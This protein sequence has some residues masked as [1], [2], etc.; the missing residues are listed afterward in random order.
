MVDRLC[1]RWSDDLSEVRQCDC[2][3]RE[4]I[5]GYEHRQRMDFQW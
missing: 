3:K 2:D 4:W 5:V 1:W